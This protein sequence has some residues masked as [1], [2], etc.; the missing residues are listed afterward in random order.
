M[1]K[2]SEVFGISNSILASSYVDRNGLDLEIAR[3]I[4]RPTHIALRGESKSGKSWLRQKMIPNAIVIQ[5]RLRQSVIDI[6]KDA[7]S[8]LG[9]RLEIESGTSGGIK[10]TV[11]AFS[12]IG[13]SIFAKLGFKVT[14][15]V[16][17]SQ[18]EISKKLVMMPQTFDLS[19]TS[20]RRVIES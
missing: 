17:V 7:L 4:G 5:C 11:E 20:L 8:Q 14:T 13:A 15:T 6:Y 2:T 1:A 19:L 12:E 16:E 3:L 18:T 10:G 9:I